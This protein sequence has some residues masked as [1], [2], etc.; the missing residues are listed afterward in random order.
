MDVVGRQQ[1][2]LWKLSLVATSIVMRAI[3]SSECFSGCEYCSSQ[4]LGNGNNAGQ[5]FLRAETGPLKILKSLFSVMPRS[6][7]MLGSSHMLDSVRSEKPALE[8]FSL[9]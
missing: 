3:S 6:S 7:H 8:T 5:P 1:V 2:N 9:I 4:Y